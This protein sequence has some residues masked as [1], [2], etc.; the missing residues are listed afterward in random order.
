VLVMLLS[1]AGIVSRAQLVGMRR[2]MIVAAVIVAAVL[3]PPDALS[4][5][6]LAV[7]LILLYEFTLIAIWFTD[8][9]K[10]AEQ[11]AEA[12]AETTIVKA[13]E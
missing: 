1:R 6:M 10:A 13:A 11:A 9:R 4:Q 5:V 7:P 12:A 8:R 3:T 2:Y